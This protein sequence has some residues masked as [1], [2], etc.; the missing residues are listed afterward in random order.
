MVSARKSIMDFDR[1]F[2]RFVGED[3]QRLRLVDKLAVI[4]E[5]Q[6]I[7]FENTVE[8]AEIN[9]KVRENLRPFEKKE[10]SLELIQKGEKYNIYKI[11][12]D[13][14]RI[15]RQRAIASKKGCDL[16]KEIQ[17]IMFQTDDLNN[18]RNSPYWRSS[19]EWEHALADEGS[20]GLYVWHEGGFDIDD[21]II[22][23]YRKPEEIH[24]PTMKTSG[25]YTDWNGVERTQDQGTEFNEFS[26]RKIIDLS[27]LK[28]RANLGDIPD[29]QIKYNE[30]LNIEKINN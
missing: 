18:A 22:D 25:K 20:K 1:K 21:L 12:E 14:Y 27:V 3:K 7:Y 10:V 28:G 23:Y 8:L 15:L 2:D 11:P 16:K 6:L 4:N 29:F 5:S 30:I 13:N 17:V 19:F 9:S 24:A 26:H